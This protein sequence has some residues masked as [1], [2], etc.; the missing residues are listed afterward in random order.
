MPDGRLL[1]A[2]A[3]KRGQDEELPEELQ[4]EETELEIANNPRSVAIV[5]EK[6]LLEDVVAG[7]AE[8]EGDGQDESRQRRGHA[9]VQ[10]L[11]AEEQKVATGRDDGQEGGDILGSGGNG[12][13][14]R[15]NRD[16]AGEDELGGHQ[17]ATKLGDDDEEGYGRLVGGP[18]GVVVR[19][20][21]PAA[22]VEKD[23]GGQHGK[24]VSHGRAGEQLEEAVP[25]EAVEEA[26]DG[27]GE[28]G[29]RGG[30]HG[31]RGA[32]SGRGERGVGGRQR[33]IG[34]LRGRARRRAGQTM[35][36]EDEANKKRRD[37]KGNKIKKKRGAK[38]W[39]GSARA[40][41]GPAAVYVGGGARNRGLV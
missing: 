1:T 29:P 31:G 28:V 2:V 33:S 26:E 24:V 34:G 25:A 18:V 15:G 27:A 3:G 10:G 22:V 41:R 4:D 8:H 23:V 5:G 14:L 20:G 21:I 16:T 39:K 17:V 6:R 40:S 13:R 9:V 19:R 37:G 32:P 12:G 35:R 36:G 11:E 7:I 30:I 38:Y